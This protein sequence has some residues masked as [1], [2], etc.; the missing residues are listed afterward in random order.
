MTLSAN[1]TILLP[2]IKSFNKISAKFYIPSYNSGRN[3][4]YSN[5]KTS[6]NLDISRQIFLP[7][8]SLFYGVAKVLPYSSSKFIV[9]SSFTSHYAKFI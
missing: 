6:K 2:P 8:K 5:S 4:V 9:Y 7:V 1:G 3:R